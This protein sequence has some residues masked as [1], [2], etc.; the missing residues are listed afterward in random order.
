VRILRG[1]S[2]KCK[3]NS[4]EVAYLL[5]DNS[6]GRQPLGES[7]SPKGCVGVNRL[8]IL[9]TDGCVGSACG[10]GEKFFAP[11]LRPKVSTHFLEEEVGFGE[12]FFLEDVFGQNSFLGWEF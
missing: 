6:K 4:Q 9:L 2:R 7:L 1:N 12:Y 10:R 11:T 3:E 8:G 5:I